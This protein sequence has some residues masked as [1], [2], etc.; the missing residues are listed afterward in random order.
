M[1]EP[2][3]EG[4]TLGGGRYRIGKLL[5]TGGFSIVYQGFDNAGRCFAIKEVFDRDRCQRAPDG[6]QVQPKTTDTQ[7]TTIHARQMQRAREEFARFRN[8]TQLNLVL[9]QDLLEDNGTVYLVMPFIEGQPLHQLVVAPF[10]ARRVLNILVPLFDAVVFLHGLGVIHRDLKPD[11]ILLTRG[12]GGEMPMLL[13]TGAARTFGDE[14]TLHTG[15]LT[16]FGAPEI[17]GPAEARRFGEPGP[18]TDVFA[19]AG[20]AFYLLTG[21]PPLG[22]TQRI[23]VMDLSK[24]GDPMGKPAVLSEQV[25]LVLKKG[26]ELSIAKR[27]QSVAEFRMALIAVLSNSPP[28]SPKVMV[29]QPPASNTLSSK[30]A[31]TDKLGS[32]ATSATAGNRKKEGSSVAHWLLALVLSLTCA[33]LLGL[34]LPGDGLVIALVFSICHLGIAL[35]L[36][37]THPQVR[38]PAFLVPFYNLILLLSRH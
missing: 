21:T 10:P 25:W 38:D 4:V 8:L 20:L 23:T 7:A 33:A 29:D 6:K 2:L 18:A 12:S 30:K 3:K 17:I 11:N 31:R 1:S 34:L 9:P 22:Y 35:L 15:I 5:G 14:G 26:L 16:P 27:Y 19:L 28:D 37:L 32:V 24:Q 13:D 36:Q